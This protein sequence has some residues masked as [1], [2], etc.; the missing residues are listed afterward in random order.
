MTTNQKTIYFLIF[1]VGYTFAVW[2]ATNSHWENKIQ[3]IVPDTLRTVHTSYL[4]RPADSGTTKPTKPPVTH[5]YQVKIDSLIEHINN[6]QANKDSVIAE[7][8][9]P[10]AFRFGD[11]LKTGVATMTYYPLMPNETKWKIQP[12]PM[13]VDSIFTQITI[14]VP[15][16]RPWYEI[17]A[18]VAAATLVGFGT[19]AIYEGIKR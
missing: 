15:E 2:Y 9:K 12:P 11:S 3:N 16:P 19:G 17:P 1:I 14:L 8:S 10:V 13:R 7:L 18:Y 6:I 5:N 4:P